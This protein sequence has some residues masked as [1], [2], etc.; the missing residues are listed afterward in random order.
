MKMTR[1]MVKNTMIAAVMMLFTI[2]TVMASNT[3][4][5]LVGIWKYQAPDAPYEYSEGQFVFT[6]KDGKLHGVAKVNYEQV[7]LEDLK[8]KDKTVTFSVY[9][10]GE[11]VEIKLDL[12]DNKLTGA[13]SYSEGSLDI[14]AVKEK[15]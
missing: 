10:E 12:K 14:T 9:V 5:K 11:Y 1:S 3:E 4:K 6:N 2:S 13:A 8:V 7:D 15:E